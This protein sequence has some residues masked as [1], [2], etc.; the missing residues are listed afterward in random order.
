MLVVTMLGGALAGCAAKKETPTTETPATE[1]PAKN[2]APQKIRAIVGAEP[3]FLD[4]GLNNANDGGMY[5]DHCFEGLTRE[6]K[7]GKT[8]PGVAESW[9]ISPDGLK[10][11][12]H[13]RDTKWTDGKPVTAKDF[14]YSWKR[15]LDPKVASEY[16]YIMYY[17]VNGEE[18]NNEK[19]AADQVGV[20]ALDDKTL[21]VNLIAPTAYFLQLCTFTTFKPVRSDVVEANGDAWVQKPETYISNGAFKMQKWGH[22]EELILVKNDNYWD[23]ANVPLD[24]IDF[25]FQEDDAAALSAFEAGEVDVNYEHMPPAEIPRLV[26]EGKYG[27]VIY[28]N[29][30]IYYYDLNNKKPPLDNPKVRQALSLAIDRQFIVDKVTMAGQIPAKGIIP[31]GVRGTEKTFREEYPSYLQPTADVA[32]AKALLAEAGFPDGKGFPTD[33][34][35]SYNTSEGHKKVAEAIQQMWKDNLGVD[36]KLTNLEWSVFQDKRKTKDFDMARDGWTA[37]YDDPM[38][39]MLFTEGGGN[40]NSNWSNKAYDEQVKIAN[41]SPDTKTRMDAMAKAEEVL[42]NE[43]GVMPIYTYVEKVLVTPK[44]KDMYISPLGKVNFIYAHME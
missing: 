43:M 30:A 25:V 15:V 27:K 36:I 31:D 23:K 8:V 34:E 9:D 32:K 12:F 44:V 6:D 5:I 16:S 7:D 22:N 11:T 4:P 26:S 19:V 41:T 20:K 42:M 40:N 35:I 33:L 24:E 37:D 13:L 14:E 10:Y 29:L 2:T 28:P 38:T 3:R 1:T 18:Y 17:L 21:E 39:F